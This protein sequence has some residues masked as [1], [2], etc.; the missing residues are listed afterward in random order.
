MTSRPTPPATPARPPVSGPGAPAR[1]AL[2]RVRTA[3]VRVAYRAEVGATALL[4]RLAARRGWSEAV[5]PYTG[6][7][8]PDHV[9]VLARVVL[10]APGAE[11]SEVVGVAGWR[12]LLTLERPGAR[13]DVEV[14]GR[15]HELVSGPGGFVDVDLEQRLPAGWSD[16][17]FHVTGRKQVP[18]LVQVA[19]SEAAVGVVCDIDDT[20][21]VTGLRH[22]LRAAWRTLARGSE[23]R[24]AVPGTAALLRSV[25][26]SQRDPAVVY[27]SNG[28]WN[29][30]GPVARFLARNGFPR[31]SLLM[32][33]WGPRP[34][35]F[36]RDGQAHKRGSLER[37]ARDLPW[38]RWV[39]V[40]DDGEHDPAIYADFIRSHPG[41]VVAVAMRQVRIVED[42][43]PRTE[44]VEGVPFVHASDGHRLQQMLADVLA[45][46]PGR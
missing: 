37:L 6:I 25:L 46:A 3:A 24:Q 7:G 22:P 26:G 35:R 42:E 10:A 43:G 33:D 30:A 39:L 45:A 5:L 13:L 20:A 31:G 29:L 9:R 19:S 2:T 41:R 16:V 23:G 40:G 14:A 34:D 18:A 4:S 36:F 8:A 1:R 32:T 44:L 21:W 12:R 17:L 11:P 27:L 28:P 38:V 15:R